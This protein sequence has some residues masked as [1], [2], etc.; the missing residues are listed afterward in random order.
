M[1]SKNE[2]NRVMQNS[3]SSAVLIS[4]KKLMFLVLFALF[5]VSVIVSKS[6]F[7]AETMSSGAGSAFQNANS[8]KAKSGNTDSAALNSLTLKMN[9]ISKELILV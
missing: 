1:N 9:K 5:F 4:S 3:K 8:Q 6:S 7:A 2:K